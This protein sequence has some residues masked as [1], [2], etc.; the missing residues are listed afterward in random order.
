MVST[1]SEPRNK[2]DRHRGFSICRALAQRHPDHCL[3]VHTAN[4]SF[5]KPTAKR[6]A[7]AFL[8]YKIA[9]LTK[10][11][12]PLLSFGYLPTELESRSK[13]K[14]PSTTHDPLYPYHPLGPTLHRLYSLRP[15]TLSFSLC[16]SPV[17]LLAALLDVIHTRVPAGS[18]LNSRSRS[19]FLS[20]VELEM[21]DNSLPR[22]ER[23]HS[24]STD[25]PHPM[26]PRDND[27]EPKNYTW[28]PTEILNWTMMQWLPG[29]ESSLRWLRQAHLDTTRPHWNDYCPVPLGISTFHAQNSNTMTPLM[30]GS[31]SWQIEWVRTTYPALQNED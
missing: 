12:L 5:T 23:I 24:G 30:W 31:T 16:D 21:Q 26:S 1:L 2:T 7:M 11:K 13:A 15:Q 9:K 25:R 3:A 29:P 6:S 20:P 28:T 14:H 4:P 27:S 10:G 17:G 19:P 22:H 8:K 18:P